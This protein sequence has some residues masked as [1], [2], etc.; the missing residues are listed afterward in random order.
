MALPAAEK[1]LWR[2]SHHFAFA[3][4]NIIYGKGQI[5]VFLL[6][7]FIKKGE[8]GKNEEIQ[9]KTQGKVWLLL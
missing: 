6:C 7:S 1:L 9:G 4:A 2:Y 3:S 5:E 8:T